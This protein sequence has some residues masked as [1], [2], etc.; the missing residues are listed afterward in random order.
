MPLRATS[1]NNSSADGSGPPNTV[2]MAANAPA[3]T[4]SCPPEAPGRNARAATSPAVRPRAVSGASGPRTSPNPNEASAA[5]SALRSW[6]GDSGASPIPATAGSP[7]WPGSRT[8]T[9]TSSPAKAGT[10]STYHQGGAVHP[11]PSGMVVHTSVVSPCERL[12]KPAA[13]T[14]TGTPSRAAMTRIRTYSRGDGAAGGP[15]GAGPPG[16][17]DGVD[18]VFGACRLI[19]ALHLI[20]EAHPWNHPPAGPANSPWHAQRPSTPPR[21]LPLPSIFDI[22]NGQ[23]GTDLAVPDTCELEVSIEGDFVPPPGG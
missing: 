3:T 9:A 12:M 22:C 10:A 2:L 13:A 20:V 18:P 23:Q 7:P 1:S 21:P 5:S 17:G 4:N 19:V 8:A 15:A 14:A 11:A 6:T 16:A